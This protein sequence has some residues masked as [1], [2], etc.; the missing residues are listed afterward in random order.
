MATAD[1]G[2]GGNADW[3]AVVELFRS[4]GPLVSQPDTWH[5]QHAAHSQIAH[6]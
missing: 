1:A 4:I 2:Q 3:M 6:R 5:G